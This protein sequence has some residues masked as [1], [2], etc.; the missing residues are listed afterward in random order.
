MA[1][2]TPR[3]RVM[4]AVRGEAPDRIPF[5]VWRHFHL[6][7]PAGAGSRMGAAELEFYRRFR[8]DLLKVMHDVPYEPLGPIH[9]PTEWA[10]VAV[11]DPAQGNFGLQLETLREIRAGLGPDVPMVDTVFNTFH[12]AN[13]LCEKRLLEQLRQDSQA[14][15]AGLRA[16]AESQAR[17]AR[18]CIEAGCDGIYFALTGASA[19]GATR[20]E[21]ARHFLSY[22]R[23]VLEAVRDA[24]LV[25]LHLHGYD[26]LYFD[27]THDLP[28]AA[29]CWSDRAGGPSLA[30]A[31]RL[32]S[33]CLMGG[34]DETRVA[35]MSA[36]EIQAQARDAVAQAAG[37][38]FI[39]APGCAVPEDTA[40]ARIDAVRAAVA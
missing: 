5:S 34:L 20:E 23:Q 16:I 22:D 4:A 27:L 31:R 28:A 21:Y 37:G 11:L 39:L 26:D 17:Y 29:L 8:P 38:G 36:E 10:R 30:E 24:P 33:G 25:I 40:P 13:Q 9:E 19:E 32:H 14:V 18:A 7:P 6:T 15:H 3:E 2:M 12:D 35:Q 1:D